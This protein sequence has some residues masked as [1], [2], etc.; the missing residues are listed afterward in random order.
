M[1]TEAKRKTRVNDVYPMFRGLTELGVT[2]CRMAEAMAASQAQVS[3]WRRGTTRMPTHLVSF[4]TEFLDGLVEQR[5]AVASYLAPMARGND[6]AE[7]Q[8]VRR[9]L[10]GLQQQRVFNRAF[11]GREIFDGLRLFQ[12]WRRRKVGTEQ[13]NGKSI[14]WRA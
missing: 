9:A 4:M 10:D 1:D 12:D 2:E 7:R 13:M 8:R 14:R 6:L 11:P 5:R 3:A